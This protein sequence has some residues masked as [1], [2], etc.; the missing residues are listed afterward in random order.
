ME[1]LIFI[2]VK[3]C[4]TYNLFENEPLLCYID[5]FKYKL[6]SFGLFGLTENSI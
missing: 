1:T 4:T 5:T 3:L 6:N 2:H